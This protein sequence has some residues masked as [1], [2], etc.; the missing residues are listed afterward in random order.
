MC[1]ATLYSLFVKSWVL[2]GT[3]RKGFEIILDNSANTAAFIAGNVTAF[4]I[5]MLAIRF[6][7]QYLQKYGFKVFGWYRIIAGIILLTLLMTGVIER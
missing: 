7:I 3:T 6:F 5:A 2:N 4:I 1:A